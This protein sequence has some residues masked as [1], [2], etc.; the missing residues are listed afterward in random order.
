MT[1]DPLAV[2]ADK[3][4][5]T[6]TLTR[7]CLAL[8]TEDWDQM[9]QVLAEDAVWHSVMNGTIE[10]RERIVEN[11]R[12]SR[13]R[14]T[15]ARHQ[16]GNIL[17]EVDGETATSIAYV[18]GHDMFRDRPDAPVRIIGSYR[19]RLVIRGGVW[20]IA[21]RSFERLWLEPH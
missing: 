2:L 16:L 10:G 12:R 5:I 4:A 9:R 8:D 14:L 19:D 18:I 13:S 21:H 20:L 7:F 3:F 15:D 11:Q 1:A 17:I 6:E